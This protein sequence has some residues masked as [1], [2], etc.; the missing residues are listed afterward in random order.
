MSLHSEQ[1]ILYIFFIIVED[2]LPMTHCFCINETL[3]RTLTVVIIPCLHIAFYSL[4]T[5]ILNSLTSQ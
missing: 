4:H 2:Q 1:S 5:S 3:L